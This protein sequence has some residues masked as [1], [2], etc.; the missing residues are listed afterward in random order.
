MGMVAAA[1]GFFADAAPWSLAKT[2]TAAMANVLAVTLDATRRIVLLI[3]PF[4]P[5]ASAA[6]LDLL[7][8]AG[9]A[10][11][12]NA[13]DTAVSPGAQLPLPQ[14]VFPRWTEAA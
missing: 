2:D 8:V 3:Q 6:L 4:T 7:G 1:N 13:L 5:A 12:F 9:D 11:D 10:R 14:G